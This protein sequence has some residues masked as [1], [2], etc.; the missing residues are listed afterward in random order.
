[1][2]SIWNPEYRG[3]I[4]RF[5]VAFADRYG[6]S[7]AL[8]TVLLGFTGESGRSPF[9]VHTVAGE[10]AHPGLWAGDR[11][12]VESFQLWL[13]LKYGGSDRLRDAWAGQATTLLHASPLAL[14][15]AKTDAAREDITHWY[16][17]AAASHAALWLRAARSAL[18][19]RALA[20]CL[21]ADL[22]GEAGA[23][24][25]ALARLALENRS[26][27]LLRP[28]GTGM[29][30]IRRALSSIRG[31]LGLHTAQVSIDAVRPPNLPVRDVLRLCAEFGVRDLHLDARS[32]LAGRR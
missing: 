10:H 6:K 20:L 17:E 18:P 30:G 9:P 19:G 21:N 15:R 13:G 25:R 7:P 2:E 32:I 5:V 28:G 1:M 12:A 29:D 23:D 22:A 31:E 8:G 11:H 14:D 16:A 26:G 24:F 4:P 3:H 27:I